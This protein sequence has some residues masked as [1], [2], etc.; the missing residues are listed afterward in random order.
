MMPLRE[1]IWEA[2]RLM[3]AL[4][5]LARQAGLV[6]RAIPALPA[7]SE[8]AAQLAQADN[9]AR[10]Q[11]V[12]QAARHLRIEAEPVS[13]PHSQVALFI[14]RAAPALVQIT[15]ENTFGYLA[16]LK[17]GR[18]VTLIAPDLAHKKISAHALRDALCAAT[19][20]PYLAPLNDVCANA[21][22]PPQQRARVRQSVLGAQLS[23]S[24][25]VQGWL[26]RLIPQGTDWAHLMRA[27][28]PMFLLAF[29]A[30][31]LIQQ[32]MTI[33]SWAVIGRGA[34]QGHFEWA[35]LWAWAMLMLMSVPLQM[36]SFNI[37]AQ[38]S[39]RFGGLFKN[40]LLYGILQLRPEEIR[41]QG[42]GQFLNRVMDASAVENGALSG[43]LVIVFS[44]L[45]IVTAFAVLTLG[46]GGWMTMG[47]LATVTLAIAF[48]GWQMW[49]SNTQWVDTYRDM[50]NHLV[51][52]MVG[53]RTRLAQQAPMMWHAQE[54][55]ELAQYLDASEYGARVG[56][57]LSAMPRVWMIFGLA[58]LLPALIWQTAAPGAIA[59]SLGGILLA[60]QAFGMLV[61]NIRQLVAFAKA[62]QQIKPL[63]DAAR[64]SENPGLF[65]PAMDSETDA[66][67]AQTKTETDSALV[68][69]REVAF[70]YRERGR[71]A[72]RDA[73]LEIFS[74]ERL[75]VQGA[76]GGGKSTLAAV[77]A[78]LRVP[79]AGLVLLRGYDRLSVGADEWRKRVV[80]APQFHEN[81]VFTETFAF[82]LL[83]GRQWPPTAQ[84][85]QD[86]LEICAALGLGELVERMPSGLSQIVG[87]SGWQLSHGERSRLFIARALL[88]RADMIILD[89]SFAALDP[90]N[91]ERALR[92]VLER[93]PTLV[94]IAHP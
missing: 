47:L 9:P 18:T 5:T 60:E 36:F 7:R 62:Q 83:M 53:Y 81:H 10:N 71:L 32:G 6:P 17:S 51:E 74:G 23:T 90:E 41:H 29:M 87:E 24:P 21:H 12:E 43:V 91:L 1:M 27:G 67:R 82:N 70:R 85:N 57:W 78:G 73:S 25:V 58:S 56:N 59:L 66:P 52:Q 35:W 50:T 20:A 94:V 28:I 84:D 2:P 44:T 54:D 15:F 31:A 33:V 39:V 22:V 68:T 65:L 93:A 92:C 48:L 13:A 49:R 8:Q 86:A 19:E 89:E 80:V 30:L 63:F 76:S 16:M 26:L 69:L 11:R 3:E 46:I 42:I 77:L 79:E 61:L 14:A 88:Q 38:L 40:T 34:L 4:E 37:T 55:A 64:R 72:L 75:I 45:Q